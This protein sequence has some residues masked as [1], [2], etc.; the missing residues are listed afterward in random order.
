MR[1]ASRAAN[2]RDQRADRRG[3]E[4]RLSGRPGTGPDFAIT[5]ERD[6]GTGIAPIK[7][8][9][10]DITR[11]VLN[12]V[13]NGF[14][15]ANKRAHGG[16][17]ARFAP[18]LWVATRQEGDAVELRV[19]DNGIG[20]PADIRDK[21]FQPFFTTKP[22]G[23]GVGLTIARQIVLSHGGDLTLQADAEGGALLRLVL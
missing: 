10:Q 5:L 20:I 14:Y 18:T 2:G 9:P 1:G 15:A 3:A 13:S 19:R 21:L 4:P 23:S 8:N 17:D 6:Y 11:V 16:A 12:L 22:D 7:V